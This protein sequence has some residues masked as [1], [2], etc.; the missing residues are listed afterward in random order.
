MAEVEELLAR[1]VMVGK[2]EVVDTAARHGDERS[3]MLREA[4]LSIDSENR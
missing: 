4:M 2:R 3:R 1:V